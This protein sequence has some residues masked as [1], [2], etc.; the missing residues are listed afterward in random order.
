MSEGQDAQNVTPGE[1]SG[2]T[3]AQPGEVQG[4]P[5]PG[6]GTTQPAPGTT[7]TTPGEPHPYEGA[8]GDSEMTGD[9]EG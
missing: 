7:P 3:P 4:E 6:E 8:E 9:E 5:T 1:E 2:A